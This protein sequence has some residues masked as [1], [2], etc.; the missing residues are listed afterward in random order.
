MAHRVC[1]WWI[2]YLLAGPWRKYLNDPAE[3]LGPYVREGMIVFEPGP[4]MGF[5]TLELAR[6]VGSTG[7]VIVVDI[8]PKMLDVL[9]RRAA[10]AGLAG[11]LDARLVQ[12][13]SLGVDGCSGQVDF[14]LAFAVVHEMPS[15]ESFFA[16]VARSLKPGGS[17]LLAEPRGHVDDQLF[18]DELA[19]AARAGLSVETRP[20]IKR[21][22]AALLKKIS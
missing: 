12:P 2:G 8:Q 13:E 14:A 5:F 16:E 6:R 7:R 20:V 21:N 9:R 19:A 11:R 17:L 15:V 22:H 3:I 10:K 4:G 18:E 1:P